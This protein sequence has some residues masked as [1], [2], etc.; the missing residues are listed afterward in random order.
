MKSLSLKIKLIVSTQVL[1]QLLQLFQLQSYQIKKYKSEQVISNE[2]IKIQ[3]AKIDNLISTNNKNAQILKDILKANQ[4]AINMRNEIQEVIDNN[5]RDIIRLESKFNESKDSTNKRDFNDL[6]LNKPG[7]MQ[8]NI[9]RG[10]KEIL[11]CF[12]DFRECE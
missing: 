12:R 7:L 10:T 11:K 9:N 4:D 8:R 3:D 2:K 5:Y 6:L 1:S